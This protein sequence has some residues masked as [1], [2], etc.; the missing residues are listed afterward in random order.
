M[1]VEDASRLIICWNTNTLKWQLNSP[2]P[3]KK[4]KKKINTKNWGLPWVTWNAAIVLLSIE[5]FA[6]RARQGRTTQSRVNV[7]WAIEIIKK[8]KKSRQTKI[9]CHLHHTHKHT[10]NIY[11]LEKVE[12]TAAAVADDDDDDNDDDDV[13]DA[14]QCYLIV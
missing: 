6:L 11:S 2:P 9:F 8:K 1:F 5:A 4:K 13:N 7:M 10:I 3:K 14:K 12:N